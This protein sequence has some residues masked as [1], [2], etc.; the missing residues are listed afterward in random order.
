M[1]YVIYDVYINTG[2]IACIYYWYKIVLSR[3]YV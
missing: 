1:T 3:I 2:Y